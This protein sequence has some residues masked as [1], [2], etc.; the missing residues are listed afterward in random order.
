MTTHSFIAYRDDYPGVSQP[1]AFAGS[2]WRSYIPLRLPW[3]L[4]IR[5]RVPPG[6]A[7]VL[8]NR[9]HTYA[10]LALP[11]D[12]GEERFYRAIDGIRSTAA[13]CRDVA[14]DGGEEQARKLF[15]RLWEHDQ[16]AF[17]ATDS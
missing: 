5:D 14:D 6:F 10:D 15:Q 13:I 12:A 4:C 17:D 16:I 3:T 7:A 1:I 2:A 8:I 9:A 11:I